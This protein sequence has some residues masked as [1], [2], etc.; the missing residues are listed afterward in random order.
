[1][2]KQKTQN[3][4]TDFTA[5]KTV[6]TPDAVA[7]WAYLD[8][9]DTAFG[10]TKHR[11]TGFFDPTDAKVKKFF[12][13]LTE[14]NKKFH[15]DQGKKAAGKGVPKIIKKA[16]EALV[17]KLADERITVGMPYIQFETNPEQDD[18]GN[19]IPVPVFNARGQR[20]AKK[21]AIW[22]GDVVSIETNIT[23]W[24]NASG[25]GVK[26]YLSAAQLLEKGERTSARANAGS[27]FGTRDDY[28]TEDEDDVEVDEPD[29]EGLE[30]EDLELSDDEYEDEYE[31][32]EYEDEE[33]DEEDDPT[34]GMV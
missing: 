32:D 3:L 1:M 14:L 30:E 9:P 12:K 15:A 11:I 33:G 7:A 13:L 4:K 5:L 10:K 8:E 6:M 27:T 31:D 2:A 21:N 23:G 16:D 34:G 24:I 17:E 18:N 29:E 20:I 22:G 28:I 19:W 26:C 25:Q